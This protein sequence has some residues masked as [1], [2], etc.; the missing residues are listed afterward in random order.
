MAQPADDE[1][2]NAANLH[3]WPASLLLDKNY[4]ITFS[5]TKCHNIPKLCM[6]DEDGKVLC[7]QCAKDTNNTSPNKAVQMMISNLKTKCLSVNDALD[8]QNN[9][10]EGTNIIITQ[11]K[12]N[13]CDWTGMIKEWD[14]HGSQ[15]PYMIV[16][17]DKCQTFKG[18][19]KLL[20]KHNAECPEAVINCPLSCGITV[21][22]KN[23]K[24][25]LKDVCTEQLLDCTNDDCKMQVKRKEFD[26]HL[27]QE[28]EERVVECEFVKY[29]CKVKHI[30]T[31]DMKKHME[32]FKFEHLLQRFDFMLSKQNETIS[33]LQKENELMKHHVM[34]KGSIVMWS[35]DVDKIPKDWKLC[36][37]QNNT[38]DLRNRFVIGA[39]DDIKMNSMGGSDKHNHD[40]IV[41]GHQLTVAEMAS[42]GHTIGGQLWVVPDNDQ[43]WINQQK[44][45]HPWRT[46]YASVTTESTGGNQAHNHAARSTENKHLPPYYALCFIIKNV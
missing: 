17:C 8:G 10:Q 25:H 12:D 9:E 27:E 1:K 29:G 33:E 36:D 24:T 21:L 4:A 14:E 31:Y 19:R 34:P 39:S 30:K 18:A 32:Q 41:D 26:K 5:C 11:A 28:C 22:R 15:C 13:Q 40:I 37:G 45:Q 6:N 20:N 38:P 43:R 35:G 46:D 3:A 2:Q 16:K 7:E 44:T 42:H 23:A